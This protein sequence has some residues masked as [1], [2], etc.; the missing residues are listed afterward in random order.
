MKKNRVNLILM[1]IAIII[2]LLL[3]Y[4]LL[5]NTVRPYG[6]GGIGPGKPLKD[7]TDSELLSEISAIQSMRDDLTMKIQVGGAFSLA[8]FIFSIN[9]VC[10]LLYSAF[11]L[12]KGL[13][14]SRE[15][16]LKTFAT[17]ILIPLFSW[18][19]YYVSQD[20]ERG[21]TIGNFFLLT[22]DTARYV[23]LGLLGAGSV[24]SLINSIGLIGRPFDESSK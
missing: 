23:C 21:I 18:Y 17:I 10:F 9:I 24:S 20:T 14:I 4:F 11:T 5:S 22:S 19:F 12:I 8:I 16:M 3:S 13:D 6:T 1:I 15:E 2:F 7:M